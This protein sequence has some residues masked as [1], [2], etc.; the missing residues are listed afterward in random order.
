VAPDGHPD[1]RLV[2]TTE[3]LSDDPLLHL[4]PRPGPVGRLLRPRRDRKDVPPRPGPGGPHPAALRRPPPVPVAPENALP[5]RR[6][7][8]EGAVR[9]P[10]IA[11][12]DTR[13]RQNRGRGRRVRPVR[14]GRHRG[15]P[16]AVPD[17]AWVYARGRDRTEAGSGE[18]RP[19]DLAESPTRHREGPGVRSRAGEGAGDVPGE[20]DGRPQRDVLPDRRHAGDH[21][22]RPEAHRKG[23]SS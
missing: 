11:G 13:D 12:L 6:R 16:P 23:K 22:R 19:G 2:S 4:R 10:A 7:G 8:G 15:R 18:C 9:R 20:G 17:H 5:E 21:R 3:G 1:R 14:G